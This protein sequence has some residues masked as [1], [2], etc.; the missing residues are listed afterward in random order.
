VIKVLGLTLGLSGILLIALFLKNELTYDRFHSKAER[1][2]RL[3][4]TDPKFLN[5]SHFARIPNAE[6]IPDLAANFPEIERFVRLAPIRGGVMFYNEKYYSIDQAFE[7]DSAF[8]EVFD[9][10][11]LIGDK[12]TI[13]N[14]PASMVV[15][16]SFASKVFGTANPIGQV[17]SI[18]PG[19]FYGEK[20]DFTIKG[21]MKDFPQNS[22]FHPE[23][24]ATP[25]KGDINWWAYVY[26]LLYINSDPQKITDAYPE[27]L[28]KSTNQPIE[29]IETKAYLQKLTDIHLKSDKLREIESNGNTTNILVLAIA[30]I[31]LLLI[32]MSNVASLNLGMAGFNLKFMTVNR[33]LGSSK[34]MNLGYFILE[35]M[36]IIG[37]AILLAIVISIPVNNFIVSNYNINLLHGNMQLKA[38]ILIGFVFF[39][40]LAGIQPALK[41]HFDKMIP[42]RNLQKT[43]SVFV[44]KGIVITQFTFA[45][46]L[47][48]AV[49]II[50]RQTNFALNNSMGVQQNNIVCFESAHANVQQKFELFK[51]ELLKHNTIE[52]VSAMLEPPGGEANDMF[53]FELEGH[54]KNDS[55]KEERIGVFPCDYSFAN[56]FNLHFLGGQNFN[57]KNL[58]VEGSG[59]YILNETALKYLNFNNPDEAIGKRFKLTSPSPGIEIPSGKIVGVVNDFHLSSL[60]KKVGPLVMFKRDRLWLINFVVA[61]KPGM[62]DAAIADMK[63]VWE[64]LFPEY[65]FAYNEVEALYRNVYKTELLQARLLSI[66]TFISLFICCLGLLGL[67]LLIAQQKIKE[68]GIRKVNGARISEVLIMLNRDFVKWVAFAFVIATPIAYFAMHKWLQNFAYKT[69]LSWWIFALA[70][71]LALGIALL[72]VSFQSWK[73]AS[74]NPVEA[75]RHE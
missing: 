19:Q 13:L 26:M 16:E 38:I 30:A 5:E 46:A 51:A 61:Y 17:I 53:L 60:K 54:T 50:S 34:R 37:V 36:L 23:L 52:S 31:I 70:G 32:S 58:D 8:F 63:S 45:I 75:L 24:I 49:M 43:K 65:P 10:E 28:A 62:H 42:G 39:A 72:T 1:I 4:L 66:F 74:R 47:I 2:Y 29:K 14:A 9:T 64:K 35:S 67:S 69:E 56:L 33:V 48:A 11:L 7:C 71:L 12:K 15:T 22:H 18:P 21:V 44:S 59:E 27:Y 6:H 41:Q 20:I 57:E 68:I 73:A 55:D 3:T 40:L 25:A